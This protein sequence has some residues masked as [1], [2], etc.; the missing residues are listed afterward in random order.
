M[1]DAKLSPTLITRSNGTAFP[2]LLSTGCLRVDRR[3]WSGTLCGPV[4]S[5][6]VF[7][8]QASL[9]VMVGDLPFPVRVS[10]DRKSH[11][12]PAPRFQADFDADRG[13]L[14]HLGN[15]GWK[16]GTV[17]FAYNLLEH[18]HEE[19]KEIDGEALV[20]LPEFASSVRLLLDRLMKAS[21]AKQ[22]LFT[23]D[24]QFGPQDTTRGGPFTLSRFWNEH[25]ARRLVY[26]AAYRL[27]DA[28]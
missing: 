11:R 25:D 6:E 16:E 28:T 27:L 8:V 19:N 3:R 21:S 17:F 5:I 23:S 9:P 20:F 12:G 22:L 18:D 14:Y 7:C 26:N 4:P 15:P 13:V 2:R 24:W 1:H 10:L